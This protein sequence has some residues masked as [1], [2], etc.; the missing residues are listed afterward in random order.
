MKEIYTQKNISLDLSSMEIVYFF[1]PRYHVF[2]KQGFTLYPK[3]EIQLLD[4]KSMKNNQYLKI[5]IKNKEDF[6]D[7][8]KE[9]KINMKIIC[10]KNG[11]G[12]STFLN[13]LK[14][15]SQPGALVR[16][17]N[18][19]SECE[20][21]NITCIIVYKDKNN[22]FASTVKSEIL[23]NEKQYDLDTIIPINEYSNRTEA[24]VDYDVMDIED[25]EFEKGILNSYIDNKDLYNEFFFN[26]EVLFNGFQLKIWDLKNNIRI[27][28]NGYRKDL[29]ANIDLYFME[30]ILKN[31]PIIFY[32]FYLLQD[33]YYDILVEKLILL[34]AE[35][36][37]E[38]NLITLFEDFWSSDDY[39]DEYQKAITIQSDMFNRD[40][41]LEDKKYAD[42]Q[43][44]DFQ[45]NV[46][47]LIDIFLGYFGSKLY[48]DIKQRNPFSS[49]IYPEGF[50]I[51]NYEKRFINDLSSGELKSCEYRYELYNYISQ[52]KG[53]FI[54]KD[55]PENYLHPEWCRQ[56][57]YL[58]MNAFVKTKKYIETLSKSKGFD[59]NPQKRFTIII[60]THS[61][62]LLSDLTND[63]I[64]YLDKD[65]KGFTYEKKIS[66]DTFA[67]NIGEM[68]CTN[69]FMD[70]TIGEFARQKLLHIV[71]D[72]GSNKKIGDIQLKSYKKLISKVGDNL[73]RNLL[74][75]KVNIYEKNNSYR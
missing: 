47:Y 15:V 51:K 10:G 35:D 3:Y 74:E 46:Y 60:T 56:F 11:V 4:Y 17:P 25:C 9:E 14:D 18:T 69:M 48:A 45:E 6:I 37:N 36:N 62:F 39:K 57:I 27:F 29:Y 32:F 40:Y 8:F 70:N 24:C 55:E 41:S 53:C 22:N 31:N 61:P 66:K 71:K 72:L 75:D 34:M 52:N 26:D 30:D 19:K 50:Y 44:L 58:Y 65:E 5:C 33:N 68:Y 7:L 20:I 73:L 23:Y 16:I 21:E 28:K 49:V 12:K 43:L 59:F 67:G 13:L 42:K 38:K 2:R 54:T 63:Y 1:I 64:I